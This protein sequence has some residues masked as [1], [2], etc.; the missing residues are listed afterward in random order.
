MK[1]DYF[2]LKSCRNIP[3]EYSSHTV[4]ILV[5]DAL[6]R[7]TGGIQYPVNS[8]HL[9]DIRIREGPTKIRTNRKIINTNNFGK[10]LV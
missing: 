8:G 7:I 2:K 1:V 10:I 5:R 3:K 6:H 4:I 9:P